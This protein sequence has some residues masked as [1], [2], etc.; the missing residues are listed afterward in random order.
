MRIG[1]HHLFKGAHE[2]GYEDYQPAE[3]AEI[4]D[5]LRVL[6]TDDLSRLL[7]AASWLGLLR[8]SGASGQKQVPHQSVLGFLIRQPRFAAP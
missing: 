6:K 1:I 8:D 3:L 4:S 7:D 2:Y 5:H